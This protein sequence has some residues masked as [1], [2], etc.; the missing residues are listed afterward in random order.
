MKALPEV[1]AIQLQHNRRLIPYPAPMDGATRYRYDV[2]LSDSSA[3][4]PVVRELAERLRTAGLR[5]WFDEW[6][7]R[8]GD[9]IPTAIEEGLEHS[10]VLLFCM[11][12]QAFGSDWALL[13]SHTAVFRDP[14]N[15]DRRFLTL[16]LDDAPIK[17]M[18]RSIA[19][20]DWRPEADRQ[21]QWGRLL[22]A[23]GAAPG[24]QGEAASGPEPEP[25]A[26]P[27][28]ANPAPAEHPTAASSTPPQ[29]PRS[30][31]LLHPV[32]DLSV[33]WSPDGARVLS[34]GDDRTVRLWKASSGRELALAVLEGHKGFV[35]S[36]G[37]SPDGSL[38][39][40]DRLKR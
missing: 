18:L 30:L 17:P 5:V 25:P 7:I 20:L 13:E 26:S 6:N 33:A 19:Y 23:C 40:A 16:R 37:W 35:L 11:S 28:P 9:H 4:K 1:T 12:A 3:D 38:W 39:T 14:L 36:V 21:A 15:R 2:F 27:A 34:G 10:A 31:Q 22:E 32:T 24:Q 29:H 8:P